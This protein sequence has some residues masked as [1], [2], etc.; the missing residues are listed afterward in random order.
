MHPLQVRAVHG[1][2]HVVGTHVHL[3]A[4][5]Q[6]AVGQFIVIGRSIKFWYFQLAPLL[7]LY[8]GSH[9]QPV[10]V[11]VRQAYTVSHRQVEGA[12]DGVHRVQRGHH[13]RVLGVGIQLV[14]YSHGSTQRELV[15]AVDGLLPLES[16]VQVVAAHRR[17]VHLRDGIDVGHRVDVD[18]TVVVAPQIGDVETYRQRLQRLPARTDKHLTQTARPLIVDRNLRV[19]LRH[20]LSRHRIAV[21]HVAKGQ[22]AEAHAYAFGRTEQPDGIVETGT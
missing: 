13:D 15:V 19:E 10:G 17:G 12:F 4:V 7:Q 9:L 18:L 22:Y 20:V 5:F 6:Q 8:V 3:P 1:V 14:A 11:A 2:G 16:E 21:A